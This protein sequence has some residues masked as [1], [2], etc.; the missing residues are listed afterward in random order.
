[1]AE[2]RLVA[3][4]AALHRAAAARVLE[5]ARRA[6][7][8]R[9]AFHWA[10]SGGSTPGGVFELLAADPALRSEFP[11]ASCQVYWGD[12]RAV[13][14]DHADSNYRLASEALLRHVSIP[15]GQ[16]HRI[17]GE[18]PDAAQA[19][20]EYEALL[21][22]ALP[23]G[24]EGLPVFDLALLGLGADGHTASLFPGT[25]ALAETRRLVVANWVGKLYAE[26]ITLTAPVFNAAREVL[27]LVA[28]ADKAPG[29]KGVIEGPFEPLQ[30]PAQLIHPAPGTLAW[31]V[32]A[33]A[34]ALL[35]PR[36]DKA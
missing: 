27:F 20:A 28:G 23:S 3:N 13:A 22:T 14:P 19:A 4:P 24:P 15:P 29:L 35:Q 26:R 1:M 9:G 11:W 10:L 17:R 36:P 6:T 30:L 33:A 31:L 18:A 21:R 7:A 25:T 8:E 5:S 2:L 16:I 12:E 34:G 32:D